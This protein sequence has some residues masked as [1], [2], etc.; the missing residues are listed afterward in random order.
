MKDILYVLDKL[1]EIF[2]EKKKEEPFRCLITTMLS[3]RT[4]DENT[5]RASERLF[6]VYSSVYKLNKAPAA[7][8]ESLIRPAGMPK[9]KASNIIKTA[10]ILVEKYGGRFL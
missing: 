9:N 1:K 10:K 5:E 2:G 7:E 8:V 6:S 4:R 3:Q